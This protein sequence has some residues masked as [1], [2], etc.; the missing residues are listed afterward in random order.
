MAK[1]AISYLVVAFLTLTPAICDATTD[2]PAYNP[3]PTLSQNVWIVSIYSG[4]YCNKVQL[5]DGT[6]WAI[7]AITMLL[8]AGLR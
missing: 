5:T 1:I 6:I 3:M 4:P 2:T 7:S 8:G